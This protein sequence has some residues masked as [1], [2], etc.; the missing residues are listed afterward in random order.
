MPQGHFHEGPGT[1][2]EHWAG[3]QELRRGNTYSAKS[4]PT[5]QGIQLGIPALSKGRWS[6]C[7][8][9]MLK[10]FEITLFNMAFCRC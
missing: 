3:E 5:C 1:G 2:V 6:I 8:C 7:L 4:S 10:L 9:V